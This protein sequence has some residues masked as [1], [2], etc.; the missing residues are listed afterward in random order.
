MKRSIK[1]TLLTLI[2][3]VAIMLPFLNAEASNI[4]PSIVLSTRTNVSSTVSSIN[5]YIKKGDFSLKFD[6]LS[7]KNE[8]GSG[9]RVTVNKESYGRL[10][11][12]EKRRVMETT[13]ETISKSAIPAKD[14]TLLYNFIM[15]QDEP[16]TSVL[17]DLSHDVRTD[18]VN[19][20]SWFKPFS[21][22]VATFFGFAVIIIFVTFSITVVLD[23]AWLVIPIL[24]AVISPAD[25]SKPRIITVAAFKSFKEAEASA[26]YKDVLFLYAKRRVGTVVILAVCIGYLMS[27]QIYA[28]LSFV[29][30]VVLGLF[31]R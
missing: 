9:C 29:I 12:D 13:L 2:M 6:F 19:A 24:N 7:V 10:S 11:F 14:R 21:G 16:V 18:Y 28:L 8:S 30:D 15:K 31:R 4:S 1:V 26:R 22:G 5:S 17:R 25:G 20:M 23:I 27:G 3:G